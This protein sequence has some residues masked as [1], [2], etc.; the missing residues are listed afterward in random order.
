MYL[1]VQEKKG[2]RVSIDRR[3]ND[4]SLGK[5]YQKLNISYL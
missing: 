4:E 5:G 1:R 2:Y 3:K